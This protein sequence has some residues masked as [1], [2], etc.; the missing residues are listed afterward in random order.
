M[1]RIDQFIRRPREYISE[2]L[3]QVILLYQDTF[4][5]EHFRSEYCYVFFDFQVVSPIRSGEIIGF[6]KAFMK[7]RDCVGSINNYKNLF[8]DGLLLMDR[9]IF[10]ELSNEMRSRFEEL[11]TI[12]AIEKEQEIAYRVQDK[13]GRPNIL[14]LWE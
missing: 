14:I 1:R 5:E 9:K 7:G 2:E 6:L 8:L 13:W 11:K 3:Q 4:G 12:E 10:V